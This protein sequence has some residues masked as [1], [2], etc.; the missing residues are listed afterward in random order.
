MKSLHGKVRQPRI[1]RTRP[2]KVWS[3]RSGVS[4][5]EDGR[6][7]I[8]RRRTHPTTNEM[9]WVVYDRQTHAVTDA[10]SRRCAARVTASLR[11]AGRMQ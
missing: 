2:V 6:R 9:L 11:N 10:F 1:F 4:C 5:H 7:Y 3:L 8:C